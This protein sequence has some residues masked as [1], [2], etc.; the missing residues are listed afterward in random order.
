MLQIVLRPIV[1]YISDKKGNRALI[2]TFH[3]ITWLILCMIVIFYPINE[4][5]VK[6]P[7]YS[8]VYL[9]YA[10]H[11]LSCSMMVVYWSC[12]PLTIKDEY[13]ALA[14]SF[15]ISIQNIILI[16]VHMLIG[17]IFDYFKD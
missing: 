13:F 16:I 4:C 6:N 3:T 8:A 11:A 10:I 17:V 2:L 7:C 5:S 1:G 14:Y 15:I 9:I 12:I